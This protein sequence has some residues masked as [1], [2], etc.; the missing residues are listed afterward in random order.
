MDM[1]SC[2]L[3]VLLVPAPRASVAPELP[4]ELLAL[5][6]QFHSE[7]ML[8]SGLDLGIQAHCPTRP[9]PHQV[10]L[11]RLRRDLPLLVQTVDECGLDED[12]LWGAPK[13]DRLE[14]HLQA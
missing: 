2:P 4:K 8:S 10:P 6:L 12:V 1:L 7:L 14:A 11:R 13:K 3:H 9:G 5:C